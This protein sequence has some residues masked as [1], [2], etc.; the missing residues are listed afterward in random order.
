MGTTLLQ[1]AANSV[2]CSIVATGAWDARASFSG[3]RCQAKLKYYLHQPAQPRFRARVVSPFLRVHTE[4]CHQC[5]MDLRQKRLDQT[6]CGVPG[7][8]ALQRC[9]GNAGRKDAV[10]SPA[11][12]AAPWVANVTSCSV[13]RYSRAVSHLPRPPI[14]WLPRDGAVAQGWLGMKTGAAPSS[15]RSPRGATRCE[16][17]DSVASSSPPFSCNDLQN[18]RGSSTEHQACI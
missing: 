15:Y 7:P 10:L 12:R 18:R 11:L 17:I 16:T 8:C 13:M 1:K 9:M 14:R 2:L 5:T 6:D 4:A 3:A